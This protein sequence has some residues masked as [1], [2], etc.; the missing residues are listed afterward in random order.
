MPVIVMRNL[1]CA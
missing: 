1:V